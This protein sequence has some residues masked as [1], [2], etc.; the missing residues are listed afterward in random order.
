MN[1]E[2]RRAFNLAFTEEGYGAVQSYLAREAGVEPAFRISE[3]PLFLTSELTRELVRGAE[4]ICAAATSDD[5]LRQSG[6]ALPDEIKV[7][8]DEERPVFLQIDFAL[9]AG[10]G[11]AVVPRL[12]ELQ[13]FPSLYGFQC[14]LGRAFRAAFPAVPAHFTPYFG[15][16]DETTYVER[17]RRAIVADCDPEQVVL[18]EIDPENQKTLIDFRAMERLIGIPTV[19]ALKVEERDGKLYYRREDG[20]EVEIRR[21]FNRVIFD[22]V[23]RKG[24]DLSHVFR[25][26]VDVTWVGHP[27]WYHR[28]S[29]F[30]LPF[31]DTPFCPPTRFVS[32]IVGD[33]P[34]DLENYVL[35]PLFSFAGLGVEIGPSAERLRSLPDPENFIL[36]R[37]VEYAPCIETPDGGAK[38][39]IR[40]MFLWDPEAG[41]KP[42]LV[43]NLVRMSKG[44]MMGVDFNKNKTWIGASSA[45]HPAP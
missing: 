2:V 32:E 17:L 19:D 26:E 30:T 24:L 5:Y 43:N 34:A 41:D 18:L 36:Q 35:K 16:L 21:V 11:G 25:R 13:A 39:E 1:P 44:A 14:I 8:G 12:I 27:N 31:L 33:L 45:Y 9:T 37:K 23:E 29:K 10:E 20:R 3:T 22:E 7:P 42:E 15:G 38:A 40:M 6:R 28:I 4:E